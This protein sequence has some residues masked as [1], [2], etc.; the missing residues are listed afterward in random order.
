MEAAM[1]EISTTAQGKYAFSFPLVIPEKVRIFADRKEAGQRLA[2][3]LESYQWQNPLILAIPPGGAEVGFEVAKSLG[4]D[5]SLIISR[6]LPF[7]DN[8]EISFGAIAEDGS[9]YLHVN[10]VREL[11]ADVVSA[12]KEEQ[13]Q[14]IQGRIKTLRKGRDLP[15]MSGRTVILIDDG[16]IIG[17]TM[18]AAFLLC[19]KKHAAKITVAVPVSGTKAMEEIKWLADEAVALE[20]RDSLYDISQVYHN[21]P[22]ISDESV[23][24]ILTE[25]ENLRRQKA[26]I[27]RNKR[28]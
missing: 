24:N 1:L 26:M 28:G 7:P 2:L 16:L 14:E 8:P 20:N 17:S 4:T 3:A 23:A 15:N 18:K 19:R 12:I 22:A 5:F 25:W 11:P 9:T 21:G 27:G 6:K 10:L 13:L